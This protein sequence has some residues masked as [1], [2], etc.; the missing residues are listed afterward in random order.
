[1]RV[2]PHEIEP[3]VLATTTVHDQGDDMTVK[4]LVQLSSS[5]RIHLQDKDAEDRQT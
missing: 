3:K 1:M 5:S 4:D 2:L